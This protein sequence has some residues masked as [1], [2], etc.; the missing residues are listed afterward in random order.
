MRL[1]FIKTLSNTKYSNIFVIT[2]KRNR[3]KKV[4]KQFK[5]NICKKNPDYKQI[6]DIL[7]DMNYN[8]IIK[9]YSVTSYIHKPLKVSFEYIPVLDLFD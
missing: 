6:L 4:I 9:I 3:N 1:S 2:S 8:N 7:H 5:Y